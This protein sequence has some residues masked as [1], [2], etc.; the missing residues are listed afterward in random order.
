MFFGPPDQLSSATNVR[1]V[2][3]VLIGEI[4]HELREENH[5]SPTFLLPRSSIATVAAAQ[6][7]STAW[8]SPPMNF[9]T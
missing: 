9:P 6:A 2:H 5:L 1:K 3:F 7:N 8:P 4:G